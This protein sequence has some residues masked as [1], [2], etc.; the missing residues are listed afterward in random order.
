MW[1]PYYSADILPTAV[2]CSVEMSDL[3]NI[4]VNP[5]LP[6]YMLVRSL[7]QSHAEDDLKGMRENFFAK[8]KEKGLAYPKY[9]LVKRQKW[10]IGPSLTLRTF[11]MS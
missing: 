8:A 4:G 6:R 11:A 5:D 2:K 1:C 3:L 10:S 9:I 7:L